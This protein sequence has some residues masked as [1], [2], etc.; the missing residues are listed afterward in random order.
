[1]RR[2]YIRWTLLA[3]CLALSPFVAGG[4]WPDGGRIEIV[5]TGRAIGLHRDEMTEAIEASIRKAAVYLRNAQAP[6]G[7]WIGLDSAIRQD[8]G[9]CNQ[10]VVAGTM[11]TDRLVVANGLIVISL[12]YAGGTLLGAV[13]GRGRNFD[14]AARLG[15]NIVMYLTQ[16]DRRQRFLDDVLPAPERK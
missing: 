10:A 4:L 9:Q 6:D 7:T 16:L 14:D 1:M 12:L 13:F 15:A 2:R 11:Q 8:K 3:A 5:G